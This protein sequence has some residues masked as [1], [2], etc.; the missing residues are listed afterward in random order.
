M[1][2]VQHGESVLQSQ[3]DTKAVQTWFPVLSRGLLAA[4]F[5]PAAPLQVGVY[6]SHLLVH[7][8]KYLFDMKG[9]K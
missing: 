1:R 8:A 6:P 4:V 5:Y 3:R 2:H 7:V 9:S